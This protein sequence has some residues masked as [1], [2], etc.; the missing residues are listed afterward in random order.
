MNAKEHR[1]GNYLQGLGIGSVRFEPDGNI[2]PDFSVG[3]ST[4]V[5]V[6]RLNQNYFGEDDPKGLEELS[7]S[8]WRILEKG[9]SGFGNRFS[10]KSYW[11]FAE[12]RRP[13]IRAVEKRPNPFGTR[14][15]AS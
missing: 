2:P 10:A 4:G 8:L 6:R 13:S 12:Y 9:A 7:I 15:K 11:I 1:A 5:K 14:W 3:S